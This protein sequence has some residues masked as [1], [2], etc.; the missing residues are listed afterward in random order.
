MPR[1]VTGRPEASPRPDMSLIGYVVAAGSLLYGFAVIAVFYAPNTPAAGGAMLV[2]GVVGALVAPA[3]MALVSDLAAPDERG[4]A[5][6]GFNVFGSLGFLTG[7]VGGATVAAAVG[8]QA[9]FFAVGFAE[10]ALAIVLFPVL[11]QLD[12][13]SGRG[14]SIGG[15]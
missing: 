10:I 3:T 12:M 6:G 15:E 8:F 13:P 5:M 11:L 7:I 14:E 2:V 9:A 4:V 1:T